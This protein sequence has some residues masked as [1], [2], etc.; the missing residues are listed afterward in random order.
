MS[1]LLIMEVA[2]IFVETPSELTI[3]HANKDS[4]CTKTTTIAKKEAA[5]YDYTYAGTRA[6]IRNKW[7]IK[8]LALYNLCIIFE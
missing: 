2:N 1:V 6:V 8:K 4:Y 3:V 7:N 5:R